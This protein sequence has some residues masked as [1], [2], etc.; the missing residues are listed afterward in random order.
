MY[1][2][3]ELFKTY[4]DNFKIACG[5]DL[6]FFAD[7]GGGRKGEAAPGKVAYISTSKGVINQEKISQ[8][9]ECMPCCEC[10]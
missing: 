9:N 8:R 1:A 6:M 5:K 10:E 2:N 3:G 4:K 7:T